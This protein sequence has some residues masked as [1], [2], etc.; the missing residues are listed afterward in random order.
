MKIS[1]GV[2]PPSLIA[3]LSRD[4][5]HFLGYLMAGPVRILIAVSLSCLS[6]CY[7]ISKRNSSTFN[8]SAAIAL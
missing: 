5:S 2:S 4:W 6:N 8:A 1:V 3:F 7:L